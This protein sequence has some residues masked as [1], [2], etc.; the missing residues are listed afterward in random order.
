MESII[1]S[2]GNEVISDDEKSAKKDN[3]KSIHYS[4]NKDENK[5]TRNFA[6]QKDP[7]KTS[8]NSAR[9]GIFLVQILRET[10]HDTQ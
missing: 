1:H 10:R 6:G 4:V 5:G 2:Q 3:R 9:V 7:S 8:Y